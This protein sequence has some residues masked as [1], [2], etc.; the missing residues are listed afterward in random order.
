MSTGRE[1]AHLLASLQEADPK[2]QPRL[3]AIDLVFVRHCDRQ[4]IISSLRRIASSVPPR[5]PMGHAIDEVIGTI[6]KMDDVA[7]GSLCWEYRDERVKQ[8][9]EGFPPLSRLSR[10][11]RSGSA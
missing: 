11:H 3:A 2:F 4:H 6:S 7:L 8:M 10:D 9:L 5:Q 1:L